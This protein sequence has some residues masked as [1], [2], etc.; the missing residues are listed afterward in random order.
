MGIADDDIERVRAASDLVAVVGEHVA[1]RR[2]GSRWVGLCPFHAE[3]TA[4]F[5]VNGDLGFYYCF[6]CGAKGDAITFVREVH[7]LDF[8]A[9]VGWLAGR[10]GVELRYDSRQESGRHRRRAALVEAMGQAVDWYHQRLLDGPDGAAARRYLRS[11][12]YDGDLVRRFR[13]GWAPDGW[14][15]LCRALRLPADLLSDTG[16]GLVNR[17]GR[18]QDRF[19]ARVLF[20][21]F[22]AR[23]DPLALGGRVLPGGSG[24]KYKNSPATPIY[25]KG[26]VLYGLNWA[27]A[28]VVASGE[29]VV[30]EGYTDVMGFALAGLAPAVAT[31]GTALT[32]RHIATLQSFAARRVV[33]AFDAD[34]AGQGAAERLYQWERRHGIDLHVAT[35]PPGSDPADLARDDPAALR[36][37]VVGATPLLAH[38]LERL[39]GTVGAEGSPEARARAAD[40]AAA[41]IAEHPNQIVREEYAGRVAV[42]LGVRPQHLLHRQGGRRRQAAP[43]AVTAPRRHDSPAVMVL[44]LAVHHPERVADVLDDV[45]FADEVHLAAYRALAGA[46]TFHQ[47]IAAAGPDAAELLQRLAVEEVDVDADDV[48]TLLVAE[49]AT[50]AHAQL[51]ARIEADY[52]VEEVQQA[53]WL[54]RRIEDLRHPAKRTAAIR[55]LVALLSDRA[56]EGSDPELQHPLRG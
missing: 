50:R 24:P 10:A 48:V 51:A 11:R 46:H 17:R 44:R 23:G 37:A 7:H 42:S 49:T 18:L 45:L 39:L 28:D 53:D 30:C 12:G 27:K 41:L 13:L 1:L 55:Q 4:S 6:G 40:G 56:E 29:V 38:R 47:A 5:S 32:D 36:A 31:C 25:D 35:L 16:L 22:D 15:T 34:A 19:R 21:I 8:V 43:A 20:P 54:R 26:S 9:A 3:R 33:L 52:R 14:D 2:S